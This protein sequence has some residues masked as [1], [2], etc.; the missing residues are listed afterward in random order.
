M[1]GFIVLTLECYNG[2]LKSDE[3]GLLGAVLFDKVANIFLNALD[4]LISKVIS[5]IAV[6][7]LGWLEWAVSAI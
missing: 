5:N 6:P 3:S 4:L 2:S 7:I 1:I